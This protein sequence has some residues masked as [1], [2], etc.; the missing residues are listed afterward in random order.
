[1]HVFIYHFNKYLL[2]IYYYSLKYYDLTHYTIYT[3]NGILKHEKQKSK[4]PDLTFSC[5]AL[6]SLGFPSHFL[7]CVCIPNFDVTCL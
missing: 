3:Q 7:Q 6:D 5:P 2:Q 4:T 1:M